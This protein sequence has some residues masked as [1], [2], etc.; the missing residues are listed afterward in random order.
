[1]AVMAS[2]F[3]H[4][5]GIYPEPTKILKI[6]ITGMM[7]AGKSTV[8]KILQE[9]G[10]PVYDCDSR[11]KALYDTQE[12]REAIENEFLRGKIYF[13]K[14]GL[15]DKK[16]A[17]SYIFGGDMYGDQYNR[18]KRLEAILTPFIIDD[19]NRFIQ[20]SNTKLVAFESAT[21]F[22][23]VKIASLFN[24]IF[25]VEAKNETLIKRAFERN[26]FNEKMYQDRMK[27]V[28]NEIHHTYEFRQ[29][30]NRKIVISN[31]EGATKEDLEKQIKSIIYPYLSVN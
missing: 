13:Y 11:V 30:Y 9:L 23:N 16:V 27:N 24:W 14:D 20:Y 3:N 22:T 4:N 18:K 15:F 7:C 21:L 5:D 6:G 29:Y 31:E 28:M 25:W 26:G 12:V 8:S 2:S 10:I 19:F 1:M 17:A